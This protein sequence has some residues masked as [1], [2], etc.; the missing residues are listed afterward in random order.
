M[1]KYKTTDMLGRE[2]KVGDYVVFTN[3]VYQVLKVVEKQ[4]H[5]FLRDVNIKLINPSP[6]TRAI[7]KYSQ[8][9]VVVPAEDVVFHLLKKERC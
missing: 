8:D 5:R 7:N 3:R 1:N 6:S 2:I 4:R 9:L